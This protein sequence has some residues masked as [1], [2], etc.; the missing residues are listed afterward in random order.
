MLRRVIADDFQEA[1]KQCDVIMGPTS[2][3][4]AFRIG[5]KSADPVQMYLSDIYTITVNLAGIPGLSLPCG[6]SSKGLPI[7]IQ[8]IGRHFREG[9][10][11]RAAHNLEHAIGFDA[12]AR[13]SPN[14]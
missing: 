9:E 12:K 3:T 2:P 13:P 7:G 11:L 6:L 8:L 14:K 4:T 1:F 10:L 5:E